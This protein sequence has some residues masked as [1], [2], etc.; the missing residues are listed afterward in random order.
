M[1]TDAQTTFAEALRARRAGEPAVVPHVVAGEE[2]FDG[3]RKER[4]DPA[5]PDVVVSVFHDAPAPLVEEA[6]AASRAAQR[7]WARVPLTERIER[8]R[9]AI[10]YLEANIDE[11]A[12]R[13]G[14]EIGKGIAGARV[15]GAEVLD[16]L[17]FQLEYAARPG[18]FEDE[19]TADPAGHANDS[20]LKP[21]GVFGVITPFNYPIVQA[22]GPTIGALIAGNGVV[23]K[24][25]SD[26]PWSGHGVYELT[27]QMDLPKGLVNVVHGNAGRALANSDIDGAS[28]T[29]SVEVGMAIHNTLSNGR[30]PRPLIAEM[31]GKNPVI[32]TDT[33]DLEL[34]ADG[35]VFSAFDLSGQKCSALSR[36]L[37]TP[38]AH[39]RLVELVE[40]RVAELLMGDPADA[41]AF[42]GPVVDEDAVER[43]RRIR[44][45]AGEAGFRIAEGKAADG[46]QFVPALVISGVPADHELAT[47]EHFLPVV[48]ISEVPDFEASITVA[49][50]TEMG[51]TAGIYTGERDEQVEFFERIEAG[52][53]NINVPGHA[54][55]GWWP[56]PQ[57]FGGW[58]ASGTTGK[59]TL[60]KWY[61]QLF[62]R[63]QSRKVAAELSQLLTY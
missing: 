51:L 19:R 33:A 2:R 35:I 62:A 45:I 26:G 34:A 17:R 15:E 60:G 37:V 48:T 47:V 59:Q 4:R 29:G 9:K 12:V 28:F 56:G 20:V 53:V 27:E 30:Y 40:E 43:H 22:A 49:N 1:T 23:I 14:L 55:T 25:S 8:M 39:D 13:V 7:E 36:V 57:T 63:Q 16:I 38:G 32:V 3:E 54:T 11:W 42:A 6:V 58:K 41:S 24:T 44:R 31:G 50:A 5:N 21:Y 10:P 61:F 52:C 46:P 18:A